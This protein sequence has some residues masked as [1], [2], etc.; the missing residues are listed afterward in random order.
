MVKKTKEASE[1]GAEETVG[2]KSTNCGCAVKPVI[3][4]RAPLYVFAFYPKYIS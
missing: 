1:R 3:G 2:L 4:E